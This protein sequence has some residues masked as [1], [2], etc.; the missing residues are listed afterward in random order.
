[1][2]FKIVLIKRFLLNQNIRKN[3][4]R[5]R[6][7]ISEVCGGIGKEKLFRLKNHLL[8]P[9]KITENSLKPILYCAYICF[10]FN[11]NLHDMTLSWRLNDLNAEDSVYFNINY[12]LFQILVSDGSMPF[13]A[14]MQFQLS[15]RLIRQPVVC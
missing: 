10:S 9:E 1:M 5:R 14:M 6:K 13:M 2:N 12:S 15:F 4:K 7:A 11:R 3:T 8:I